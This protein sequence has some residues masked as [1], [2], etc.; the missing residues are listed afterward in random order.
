MIK[1]FKRR[2]YR[3]LNSKMQAIILV[4]DQQGGCM[5]AHEIT[6]ETGLSYITVRKYLDYLVGI[7]ILF[8]PTPLAVLVKKKI[9]KGNRGPTRRYSLNYGWI[10]AK[11][12]KDAVKRVYK[13]PNWKKIKGE[14]EF[15]AKK[16][17]KS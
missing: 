13:N 4:L 12:D 3:G 8:E 5:S 1:K 6:K 15:I 16:S 14:P 9:K 10:Y 7:K 11:G 17:K 2:Q